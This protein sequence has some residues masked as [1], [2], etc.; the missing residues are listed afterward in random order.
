M[1]VTLSLPETRRRAVAVQEFGVRPSAPAIEHLRELAAL[2]YAFQIDSVNVLVRAQYVPAFARL[3]PYRMDTLD[4]LAYRS[5]ELFEYWVHAAS[6]LPTSL[7]SLQRHRMHTEQ[8]Q[9]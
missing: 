4:A 5:R 6:L 9:E 7:Y 3:G 1:P 8:M 2:I